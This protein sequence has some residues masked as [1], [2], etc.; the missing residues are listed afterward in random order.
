MEK[1]EDRR[2][3]FVKIVL[4]AIVIIES[5]CLL[6]LTFL[7]EPIDDVIIKDLEAS[8]NNDDLVVTLL[9]DKVQNGKTYT[10]TLTSDKETRSEKLACAN[11]SCTA[12][13][14]DIPKTSAY[15]LYDIFIDVSSLTKNTS[16]FG[17]KLKF[18]YLA[19]S[20]TFY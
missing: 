9:L 14:E 11:T 15:V 17:G 13:F 7:S 5:L 20:F 3:A 18:D 8:Y 12:T 19:N 16:F 4:I 1:S 6:G 2:G 10:L